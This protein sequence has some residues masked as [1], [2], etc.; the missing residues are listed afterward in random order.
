MQ[1]YIFLKG[2]GKLK[3]SQKTM[4]SIPLEERN[5]IAKNLVYLRKQRG[6]NQALV[7]ERANLSLRT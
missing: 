4:A 7:A 2:G 5:T 1:N 3:K 6:H